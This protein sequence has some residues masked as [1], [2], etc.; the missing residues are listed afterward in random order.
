MLRENAEHLLRQ[1][2][3]GHIKMI[4]QPRKSRPADVQ[5]GKDVGL[6]PL[7]DR[8]DLLPVVHIFKCQMLYRSTC[9]NAAIVILILNFGKSPIKCGKMI[10]RRVLA[11]MTGYMQK[12]NIHLQR[13]VA[14][15]PQE[16]TFRFNFFRH[17]IQH[18]HS[19]RANVLM[20]RTVAVHDKNILLGQNVIRRQL[21]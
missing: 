2:I 9:D 7:H 17:Q 8:A 5:R 6:C 4:I 10:L 14:E 18:Q 3:L 13:R 19:Q 21:R 15:Q 20:S 1:V 11:D 12:F 16:L